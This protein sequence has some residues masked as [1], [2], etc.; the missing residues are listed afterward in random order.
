MMISNIL[1]LK[2]LE[3]LIWV[4]ELGS[5][6]K[7]AHHLNTTQPNIST[8]IATLEKTL[9]VILMQ[10]DAGS[11]QLT[12]KG[13]E[14]LAAGR[15]VLRDAERIVEVSDRRDLV[16]DRLRLG[17]TELV[18]CTWLH[19][20]LR[21]IKTAYPALNVEL[22]VD[23]SRNLD[24][25]LRSNQLD[26]AIQSAPFAS[27]ANGFI[28]LGESPYIWVAQRQIAN[29][30]KGRVSVAD[31]LPYSVLTHARHTQA[32]VELEEHAEAKSLP[33][34]RFVS[35]NSLSSCVQMAAD[36]M[37][38]TLLPKALV[39]RELANKRLIEVDVNWK[40]APLRFAARYH[41][42]K[43]ALYISHCAE[44]AADAAKAFDNNGQTHPAG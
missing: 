18:A 14:I 38:V 13:R 29:K 36:G 44:L 30:I 41:S 16:A 8:R 10:R 12:D 43:A 3:A 24:T 33:T 37:G 21:G 42:E 31:L 19:A 17:V 34:A 35:S 32:Y 28:E 4:A 6:R 25:E 23:L 22:T 7:A 9:G 27:S 40:P 2:Q 5:F 26:L 15:K 1:N 11:I 20:Y 39:E